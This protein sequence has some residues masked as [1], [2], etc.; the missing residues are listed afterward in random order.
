MLS[1]PCRLRMSFDINKKEGGGVTCEDRQRSNALA[2][3]WHGTGKQRERAARPPVLPPRQREP[4]IPSILPGLAGL[5]RE[6]ASF[7]SLLLIMASEIFGGILQSS[8][9]A[10]AAPRAEE[11]TV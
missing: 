2:V 6:I 11:F 10:S 8:L 5:T 9:R 1:V 3:R 7:S 4:D